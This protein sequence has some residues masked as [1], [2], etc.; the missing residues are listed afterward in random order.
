MKK[1][2]L[3]VLCF[4]LPIVICSGCSTVGWMLDT[5]GQVLATTA[6]ALAEAQRN[7]VRPVSVPSRPIVVPG[8]TTIPPQPT[9][10]IS[11]V[12]PQPTSNISTVPEHANPSS[13][14][15]SKN[16][17]HQPGPSCN[18]STPKHKATTTVFH[19]PKSGTVNC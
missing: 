9:S 12:P 18:G 4:F 5:T 17:S 16:Q 19:A 1:S 3:N 8:Q 13:I 11:T 14:S 15:S 6:S 10:R 7:T 2:S